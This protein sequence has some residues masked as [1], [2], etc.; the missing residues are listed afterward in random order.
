VLRILTVCTGNICRSPLAAV[1]LADGLRRSGVDAAVT[2]CGTKATGLRVPEHAHAVAAELG[3]SVADH[4]ARPVGRHLL[5]D[6]GADLI[7]CMDRGHL[8]QVVALDPSVWPRTFTVKE[9]AR[10]GTQQPP[11]AGETLATWLARLSSA[12]RP[13]DMMR[14]DAADD[15]ADPYG[16]TVA[17][18]RQMGQ[19][20]AISVD[21]IVRIGPW[22]A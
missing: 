15:L 3:T 4:R 2:S 22:I 13:A 17:A 5:G 9:L 20:L 8:R 6:D 7:V 14:D 18:Y 1:L 11:A 10:R 12:R 21:T 19:E 16:R